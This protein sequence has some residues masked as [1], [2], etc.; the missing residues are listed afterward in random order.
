MLSQNQTR[1]HVAN[2]LEENDRERV[3]IS[4]ISRLSAASTRDQ[5]YLLLQ[6]D[7]T[8]VPV[9]DLM[10]SIK[11]QKFNDMFRFKSTS[12]T[13][14]RAVSASLKNNTNMIHVRDRI[15]RRRL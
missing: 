4:A 14:M 3:I 15:A 9:T 12:K 7:D 10:Y 13:T 2:I 11:I 8:Q 6:I 5:A 1:I